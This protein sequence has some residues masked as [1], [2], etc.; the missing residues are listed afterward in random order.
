MMDSA[1]PTILVVDDVPDNVEI[2]AEILGGAYRV[3]FALNGS[4][5]LAVALAEPPPSL[6]LLDVV[7]PGLDGH[8]VCRRLKAEPR[9]RAIPVIF[10]SGQGDADAEAAGLQ[11]GAVG[12]LHKPCRAARVLQAVG[13]ALLAAGCADA[14]R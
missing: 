13:A 9:T 8:E 10:L 7:M 11:L 6:I 5:A 3:T 12:F 2:L 4:D 1:R 14:A